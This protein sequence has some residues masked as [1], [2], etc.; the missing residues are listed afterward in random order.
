M[1]PLKIALKGLGV[2]GR[3][4]LSAIQSQPEKFSLGAI[5]SRHSEQASHSW[6][7]VLAD[8]EIEAIAISTENTDHESSVLAALL[9]KKH[10]LC[11]YPLCF[12]AAQAKKFYDLAQTQQR[13]LHV[14]HMG[15]LA[16]E[17]LHLRQR[18]KTGGP[19]LRA[20]FSFQG[21][22][23]EKLE[24]IQ[25]SGPL[26]FSALPRLLQTTDLFGD[27]ALESHQFHSHPQGFRI[28]LR[29]KTQDQ[30]ELLFIEEHQKGMGRQRQ[31][32]AL[33]RGE[34]LHW[35]SGTL[36]GGLFLKDL[37][38]FYDRVRKIQKS[39][40]YSERQLLHCIDL[41]EKISCQEGL[42]LKS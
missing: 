37:L 26:I 10:V 38:W 35:Q 33:L 31:L 18:I 7:E 24:N 2:A 34:E 3:A 20:C 42:L 4:R 30:G 32:H 13:V 12:S 16:E 27:L 15:L 21:G 6:E 40:Y 5:V 19:L 23:S 41:L 1:P 14:E 8:P 17:H 29:L 28:Q 39:A 11:D 25:W 36:K 22:F 9:A